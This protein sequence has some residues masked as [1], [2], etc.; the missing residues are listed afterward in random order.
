MICL[1]PFT[2]SLLDAAQGLSRDVHWPHRRDDWA[3][4]AQVSHGLAALD[5]ERVVGT[6][7]CTAMGKVAMLNMI[8]V[9]ASHQGRGIGQRLM[10]GVMAMAGPRAMRLVA[11]PEGLPRYSRLGFEP[12]GTIAQHQGIAGTVP[13]ADPAVI[14]GRA[15]DLDRIAAL[16]RAATGMD[17]RALLARLLERGA[18]FLLAGGFAQRRDFGK[19]QVI[20][21]VVAPDAQAARALLVA[22]AAGCTGRFLR[23]DTP[24]ETGLGPMIEALGLPMVA[25]GTD[26][27]HGPAP[28]LGPEAARYALISQ[29]LG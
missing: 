5:G 11:T 27:Q 28:R 7:F 6:A 18:L 25:L 26:M 22:A 2:D 17:R 16:D 1:V 10:E 19:G 24:R 4:A 8:I 13:P 3:L 15:T 9:A 29:A 20:G 12:V 14:R 21:P 23:V